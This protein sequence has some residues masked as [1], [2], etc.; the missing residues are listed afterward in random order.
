MSWIRTA[1]AGFALCAS[2]SVATAQGTPGAGS[3]GADRGMR[4]GRGQAMLFEGITLTASQEQKVDSIRAAYRAERQ[5]SSP[6]G[7][8]RP[9]AAARTKMK[10]AMDKQN[11]EIRALLTPEQQKVFDANIATMK[12]RR[13]KMRPAPRA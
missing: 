1:V 8:G 7:S 9:D 11:A 2:A 5:K 13:G 10:E 3:Q 4:G 12:E 6:N